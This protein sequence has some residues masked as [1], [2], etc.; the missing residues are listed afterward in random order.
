MSL[1][2]ADTMSIYCLCQAAALRVF[3]FLYKTLC[4]LQRRSIMRFLLYSLLWIAVASFPVSAQEINSFF[5]E[6]LGEI[7]F[8]FGRWPYP[9][10]EENGAR[11]R[12]LADQYPGIATLHVIG[13]TQQGRDML[14]IEITNKSTGPART[15]RECGLTETCMP[16]K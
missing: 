2:G 14:L 8:D 16:A 13:Q 4:R 6:E 3:H 11:L 1:R 5:Q 9:L 12:V 7:D 10:Y 15:S